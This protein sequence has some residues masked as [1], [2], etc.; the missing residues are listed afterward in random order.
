MDSTENRLWKPKT[1]KIRTSRVA[2]SETV[3]GP[4]PYFLVAYVLTIPAIVV[5]DIYSLLV[6]LNS[7]I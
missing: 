6:I 3:E 7:G 1:S 4:F 2:K 5:W